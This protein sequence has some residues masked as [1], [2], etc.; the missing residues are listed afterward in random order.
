MRSEVVL[1][2]LS[3]RTVDPVD[4]VYKEGNDRT[5]LGQIQITAVNW[6]GFKTILWN[7]FVFENDIIFVG[8]SKTIV[9][10]NVY[11]IV[12]RRVQSCAK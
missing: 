2:I 8:C 5:L 9:H 4:T 3:D 12:L 7:S 1:Y 6:I 10:V 11:S